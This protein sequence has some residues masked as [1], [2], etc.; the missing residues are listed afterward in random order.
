M[1]NYL[2]V[3]AVLKNQYQIKSIMGE[4]A[5]GI[6]YEGVSIAA[7][8]KVVIR[9]LFPK[10]LCNRAQDNVNITGNETFGKKKNQ[11]IQDMQVMVKN[12]GLQGIVDVY[13][14]FEEYGT[15]Y[16]IMEFVDGVSLEKYLSASGKQFPV[17]RMKELLTPVAE[18]LAVLHQNGVIH[19]NISPDNLIFTNK[20]FLK[21]IGFGCMEGQISDTGTG[22][23]PIELYRV[24]QEAG[25]AADI[26]SLCASIY[27]CVTGVTPQ[28][29]YARLNHDQLKSPSQLGIAIESGDEAALMMGLNIYEEKRFRTIT[30]FHNA[31]FRN[32]APSVSFIQSAIPDQ[33]VSLALQQ[34]VEVGTIIQTDSG[35]A[36]KKKKKEKLPKKKKSGNGGMIAGVIIGGILIAGLGVSAFILGK[37]MIPGLGKDLKVMTVEDATEEET[38]ENETERK[39]SD[40]GSAYEEMLEAGNF[41]GVIEG[42]LALDTTDLSAEEKDVLSNSLSQ[43]IEGQYTEFE[44]NVNASQSIGDFDSAFLTIDEEA[45][46]YDRLAADSM[47]VQYVDKQQIEDKRTDVK[48]AHIKYLLGTKLESIIEQGNEEELNNMIT[49]LQEYVNSGMMSQEAFETKKAEAYTRFVIERIVVMNNAGTAPIDIVEYINDKLFDTGNNCHVLEYWDYFMAL[50]GQGAGNPATVKPYSAEGYLLPGSD[51]RNL[52][53]SD[54]GYFSQDEL[55]LAIYEIFA[56]HGKIFEDQAVNDYFAGF[57][58]YHPSSSYDEST[59]NTFEKYNLNLLIEYQKMKGYR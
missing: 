1:S 39:K 28:D 35:D 8:V 42:I 57:A 55:R 49:K 43:A 33:P 52:T 48:Q 36:G 7:G 38:T 14:V 29:A 54:I 32:P 12:K 51:T 47:A 58:W 11:F 13:D 15:A 20:G 26:Y 6:T 50:A 10:G 19:K 37:D 44:R 9:E 23:V 25:P 40:V 41:S 5:L 22:Y 3:N 2:D 45:I 18:S 56:R 59:L 31:F 46:L 34:P 4:N 27:R 17:K 21:L 53:T 30:A 24:Q 16:C